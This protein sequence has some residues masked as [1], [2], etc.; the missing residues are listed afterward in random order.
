MPTGKTPA[1]DKVYAPPP[2]FTFTAPHDALIQQ[3][4]TVA[5]TPVKTSDVKFTFADRTNTPRGLAL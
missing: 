4:K 1:K 3:S 5:S 2:V